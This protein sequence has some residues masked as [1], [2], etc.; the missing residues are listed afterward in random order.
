MRNW[1]SGVPG[2]FQAEPK[3]GTNLNSVLWY[4]VKRPAITD[5]TARFLVF[6]KPKQSNP[7]VTIPC[8]VGS[9]DVYNGELAFLRRTKTQ[10]ISG[11]L[12]ATRGDAIVVAVQPGADPLHV[13]GSIG[14]DLYVS[15][16]LRIGSS[17]GCA[18]RRCQLL[19]RRPPPLFL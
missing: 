5:A 1:C 4:R 16:V 8:S 13:P 11:T 14:R 9:A 17:P 15:G 19:C 6:R 18:A 7:G 10:A 12:V 2:Y 3:L